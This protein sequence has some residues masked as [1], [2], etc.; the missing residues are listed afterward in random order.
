[1]KT[2]NVIELTQSEMVS[3]QGGTG[4]FKFDFHSSQKE[5]WYVGVTVSF[6]F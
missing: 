4:E 3:T 5:G 2:L 6:K 1:M